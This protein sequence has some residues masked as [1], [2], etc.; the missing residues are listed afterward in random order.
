[1]APAEEAA[2]DQKKEDA[3]PAASFEA[4]TEQT[5]KNEQ[6]EHD[7]DGRRGLVQEW[8][9]GISFAVC[10]MTANA[11]VKAVVKC[12]LRGRMTGRAGIPVSLRGGNGGLLDG[13]RPGPGEP[14]A[15][16]TAPTRVWLLCAI[17][18]AGVAALAVRAWAVGGLFMRPSPSKS[19]EQTYFAGHESASVSC[20]SQARQVDIRMMAVGYSAG[21]GARL[22]ADKGHRKVCQMLPIAS[23]MM[24]GGT[25]RSIMIFRTCFLVAPCISM[26]I[27]MSVFAL[28]TKPRRTSSTS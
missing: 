16:P 3:R 23:S 1:M 5:E 14:V 4:G 6:P 13:N 17:V 22:A 7:P 19:R 11:S 24:S 8:L 21:R 9:H 26:S 2:D 10:R 18:V 25:L 15:T 27:A 12:R 28:F 20:V